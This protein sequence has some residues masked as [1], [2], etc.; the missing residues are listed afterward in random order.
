MNTKIKTTGAEIM[1]NSTPGYLKATKSSEIR[2]KLIRLQ[3][4]RIIPVPPKKRWTN[5]GSGSSFFPTKSQDSLKLTQTKLPLSPPL[6][7]PAPVLR[8]LSPPDSVSEDPLVSMS[9]THESEFKAVVGNDNQVSPR[10]V[11]V[12]AWISSSGTVDPCLLSFRPSDSRD[13][14]LEKSKKKERRFEIFYRLTSFSN[15]AVRFVGKILG[16]ISGFFERAGE[17][18][19]QVPIIGSLFSGLTALS[20]GARAAT[21]LVNDWV[22]KVIKVIDF[23]RAISG[24]ANVLTSMVWTVSEVAGPLA[25]VVPGL[26]AIKAGIDIAH[27]VRDFDSSKNVFAQCAKIF[28]DGLLFVGNILLM[29]PGINIIVGL[30]FLGIGALIRLAL[31]AKSFRG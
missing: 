19:S 5:T 27:S 14:S 20:V 28:A 13:P 16:N 21:R 11:A 8:I 31:V 25:Y 18:L 15:A 24:I 1:V 10:H 23:T 22:G 6:K 17:G 4:A 29:I 2:S 12:E 3:K 9:N 30:P 7:V 26:G